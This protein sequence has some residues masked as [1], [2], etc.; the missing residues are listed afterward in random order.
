MG[1][2]L[3]AALIARANDAIPAARMKQTA[4]QNIANTTNL[5]LTFQ[6]REFDTAGISD[7][8]TGR[9]YPNRGGIWVASASVRYASNGAAGE[10]Y[11]T[12]QR[13]GTLSDRGGE[14]N[15]DSTTHVIGLCVST[16][17]RLM[18]GDYLEAVVYQAAG[19]TLA[20]DPSLGDVSFEMAWLGPA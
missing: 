6:Q 17:L 14:A 20:T 7:L 18:P 9:L 2:L 19:V 1:A 4:A 5:A 16:V 13:N 15:G 11:L 12:I 3:E 10:R 8:G